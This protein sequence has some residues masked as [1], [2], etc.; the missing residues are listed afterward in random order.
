MTNLGR[1]VVVL[2]SDVLKSKRLS[3][4]GDMT[5]IIPLFNSSCYQDLN[6]HEVSAT[7][8]VTT[9]KPSRGPHGQPNCSYILYL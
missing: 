3:S 4:S 7:V 5:K 8:A 2:V 9:P 1:C 6:V